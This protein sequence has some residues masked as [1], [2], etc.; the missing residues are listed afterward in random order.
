MCFTLRFTADAAD[1]MDALLEQ[2][3]QYQPVPRHEWLHYCRRMKEKYP[4]R[5][6]RQPLDNEG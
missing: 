1:F 3:Y 2:R 4:L 6:E 5:L